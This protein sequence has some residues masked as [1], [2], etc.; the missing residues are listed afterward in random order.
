MSR[1]LRR[2]PRK[3]WSSVYP[4]TQY[5]KSNSPRKPIV[6]DPDISAPNLSLNRKRF[7]FYTKKNSW[8]IRGVF[9]SV[10]EPIF[11]SGGISK[12]SGLL[13]SSK[14]RWAV[15]IM[16]PY[17]P[18]TNYLLKD[19]LTSNFCRNIAISSSVIREEITWRVCSLHKNTAHFADGPKW[20]IPTWIPTNL[21]C[22]KGICQAAMNQISE[23]CCKKCNQMF[24]E[25]IMNCTINDFDTNTNLTSDL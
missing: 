7:E 23:A 17:G 6:W 12:N 9:D 5:L 16:L 18:G 19:K 13:I 22:Q 10:V 21:A 4:Q 24:Y 14:T 2:F 25:T 1:R 15:R 3:T 20:K 11:V 8:L